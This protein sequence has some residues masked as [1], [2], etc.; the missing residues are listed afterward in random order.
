MGRTFTSNYRFG[1]F[2]AY[3]SFGGENKIFLFCHVTSRE[4]MI[5][6]TRDLLVGAP[7]PKLPAYQVW[8][9]VKALVE[10]DTERF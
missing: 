3:R 9:V 8:L 6:G 10:R 5:K 1:K 7:Y 4:H 2:D